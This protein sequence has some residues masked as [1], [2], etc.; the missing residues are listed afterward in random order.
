MKL[1]FV[2]LKGLLSANIFYFVFECVILFLQKLLVMLVSL[3]LK[4]NSWLGNSQG[5]Q[6][7]DD[8]QEFLK[9]YRSVKFKSLGITAL[10]S[11][12]A[13]KDWNFWTGQFPT[14]WSIFVPTFPWD[15]FYP[16][17]SKEWDM[18]IKLSDIQD[19][20]KCGYQGKLFDCF[21]WTC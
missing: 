20:D 21:S 7:Y 6:P 9:F 8:P 1:H 13:N 10:A 12:W 14:F 17:I 11:T 2:Q 4:K 19:T 18:V 15:V 16:F 3:L 5:S